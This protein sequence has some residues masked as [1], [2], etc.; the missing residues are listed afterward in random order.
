MKK[1]ILPSLKA[2]MGDWSYYIAFMCMKDI[3]ER[4]EMAEDIHPSNKL[5]ELIQRKITDRSKEI[6]DYLITQ[7][8]RFF[9]SII[10]GIYGGEPQWYELSVK[11]N[12]YLDSFPTKLEGSLGFLSLRGDE[13]LFAIDGQHRVAAI[14]EAVNKNQS[15]N[16][17]EVSVIFVGHKKDQRGL[18]RT[19][20]LFTTLNRYAKPVSTMEIIALDEDDASAIITRDLIDNYPLFSKDIILTKKGKSIPSSNRKSLTTIV[21]LYEILNAILRK[22]LRVSKQFRPSDETLK[23]IYNEAV[24]FWDLMIKYFKPLK[25]LVKEKQ[26]IT[27]VIER[28]RNVNG[29]SLLFRPVGQMAI[30]KVIEMSRRTGYDMEDTIRRISLLDLELTKEPWIGIIWESTKKVIITKKE[31]KKLLPSLILY[32][33]EYDLQKFKIDTESLKRDYAS[34]LGRDPTEVKLPQKIEK[35]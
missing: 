28:Y 5:R 6:S 23:L 26:D 20:R 34:G 10:L 11:H 1:L 9:N 18:E 16:D 7:K 13:K 31:N 19:R 2:R 32:M 30:A 22:E 24:A 27:K 4:V 35:Y 33:I 25:E 8:Q 15:L 14:K 3:A 17:E 12:K 29:G 21:T